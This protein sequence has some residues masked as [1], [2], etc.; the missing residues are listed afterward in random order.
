MTLEKTKSSASHSDR[1]TPWFFIGACLVTVLTTNAIQPW[2]A[3]NNKQLLYFSGPSLPRDHMCPLYLKGTQIRN[4]S[5][6]LTWYNILYPGNDN[7]SSDGIIRSM[8]ILSN[9]YHPFT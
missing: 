7:G 1:F 2:N 5:N 3:S 9:T 4:E 8:N 6:K